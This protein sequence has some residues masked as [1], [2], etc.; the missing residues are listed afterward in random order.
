M[1]LKINRKKFF[2][3]SV[4]VIVLPF[5]ILWDNIV[6]RTVKQKSLNS[7][8]I[9]PADLPQG[10]TFFKSVII[11]K[12]NKE[13]KVFSSKCTHLGCVISKL[14]DGKFICSCHGSEFN[15]DGNVIKDPATAS[16]KQLSF[17]TDPKTKQIV[18]FD[19]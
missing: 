10:I 12:N 19:A 13:L 7:K 14:E 16:L 8:L 9:L 17:K 2:K 5:L 4:A 15:L 11:K 18:I 3:L 1:Q 6:E